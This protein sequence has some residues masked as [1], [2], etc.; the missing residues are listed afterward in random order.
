MD[1]SEMAIGYELE[2][3]LKDDGEV[4]RVARKLKFDLGEDGSVSCNKMDVMES[5]LRSPVYRKHKKGKKFLMFELKKP[6]INNKIFS[7]FEQLSH[8]VGEINNSMGLHIHVSFRNKRYYQHLFSFAFVKFFQK[9]YSKNFTT[10]IEKQRRNN[11]YCQ[12]YDP[13][14]SEE[15]KEILQGALDDDGD[16]DNRFYAVNFNAYPVHNTIEFR[17]FPATKNVEDFKKYVSFVVGCVTSFV[18]VV[19]KEKAYEKLVD[20]KMRK[21]NLSLGKEWNKD[22]IKVKVNG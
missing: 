20:I 1:V 2:A 18:S 12:F 3:G 22:L 6:E 21:I 11:N 15:F 10:R 17:I 4:N 7:D 14:D 9:E 13:T 8:Y 16:H 5:E 19:E